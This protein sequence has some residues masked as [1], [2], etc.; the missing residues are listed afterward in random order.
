MK[1]H[2]PAV[3]RKDELVGPNRTRMRVAV[4]GAGLIVGFATVAALIGFGPAL[5][6][7]LKMEQM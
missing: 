5:Y 1:R 2:L 6:R 3:R 4:A 7:Y